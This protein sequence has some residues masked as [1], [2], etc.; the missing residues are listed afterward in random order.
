MKTAGIICECNP[1]H[2]GHEY[3]LHR[4][5]ESGCDAVVAVMSGCFVQRG[6]AAIADPYLRGEAVLC[7]GA[8]AVLELPFPYSAA[9]AEFFA[10]AGVGILS[11]IGVDALWFGSECGNIEDLQA[12]ARVCES[13]EFAARYAKSA[14]SEQG[15]AEAYFALLGKLCQ[16]APPSPNDILGIAYLRALLRSKADII[17]VTVAREGSGYHDTT[18]CGSAYPSATAL[19]ALWRAEGRAAMLA[20][21]PKSVRAVYAK[22][23]EPFDLCHAERFILGRLRLCEPEE[24]AA[25][26]ELSGGLGNRLI[27]CACEA[28]SLDALLKLAATKKYPDARIKRGILHALTGVTAADLRH[29]P[30]YL[31]LLAANR[32]GR[33]LLSSMRRTSVL[34]IVTRRAD[35]PDTPDAQRQAL[36][37]ERAWSLFALC[38]KSTTLL[39]SPWQQKSVI[40]D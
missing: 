39:P 20:H 26:A 28:D 7:A 36:L 29:P 5:R 1:L 24:L 4:V 31:R 18:L 16:S 3:L 34:P 37:E 11:K 15:S 38:Q 13:E 25:F 17:P 27:R 10:S 14:A 23:D 30:A 19:R 33:E 22:A 32:R 6:E 40:R 8:D 9:S 35:L 2:G 21:L 12:A